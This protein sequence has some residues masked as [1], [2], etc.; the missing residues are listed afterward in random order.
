VIFLG[1]GASWLLGKLGM[2]SVAAVAV[3][4][5]ALVLLVVLGMLRAGSV[6]LFAVAQLSS[7]LLVSLLAFRPL[8]R[9]VAAHARRETP[10]NVR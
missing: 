9:W 3:S 10:D 6:S 1:G 2:P 4:C 7:Y 5:A 8:T